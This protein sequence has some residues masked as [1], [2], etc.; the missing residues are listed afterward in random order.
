MTALA[1][2]PLGQ[3]RRVMRVAGRRGFEA[4]R[5]DRLVHAASGPTFQQ[6]QE[7]VLERIEGYLEHLSDPDAD[8]QLRENGGMHPHTL[9]AWRLRQ[10]G[11]REG[12]RFWVEVVEAG[13]AVSGRLVADASTGPV[14]VSPQ[15]YLTPDELAAR[16]DPWE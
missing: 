8:V 16:A 7:R 2:V 13:G 5:P 1:P 11:L 14:P 12:D 15:A 4:R 6:S 3:V 10:L 9:P